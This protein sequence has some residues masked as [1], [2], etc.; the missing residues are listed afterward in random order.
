[1]PP[2]LTHCPSFTS[3]C[4]DLGVKGDADDETVNVRAV[5]VGRSAAEVAF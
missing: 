4:W 1:M 5:L 3:V 2:K